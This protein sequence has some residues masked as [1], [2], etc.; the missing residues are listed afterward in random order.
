MEN[1][2]DKSEVRNRL[3]LLCQELKCSA[4][5]FS[6]R[7]GKS[8]S[9]IANL[10]KDMTTDVLL[11]IHI[12]YPNVNIMWLITGEG[13]I[14]GSETV[15]TDNSEYILHLKEEIRELKADNKKLDRE[16]AVLLSK[17]GLYESE[18]AG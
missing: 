11:N 13:A 10:K 9:Y 14:L 4:R 1:I 5:E 8:A 12:N 2:I 16:N 18:K 7:I 3:E 15:T 6:T 17:L